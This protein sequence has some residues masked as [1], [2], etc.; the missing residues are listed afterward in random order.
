VLTF[1]EIRCAIG[2]RKDLG[3]P[4]TSAIENKNSFMKTIG[5]M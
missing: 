4:K 2:S 5:S 3:R 1:V